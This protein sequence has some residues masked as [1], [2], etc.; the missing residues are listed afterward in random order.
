LQRGCARPV[1]CPNRPSLLFE[2]GGKI[3]HIREFRWAELVLDPPSNREPDPKFFQSCQRLLHGEIEPRPAR[4]P[5]EDRGVTKSNGLPFVIITD[6]C[7][8]LD[9]KVCVV[10]PCF[11]NRYS[12]PD[13]V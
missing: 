12:L 8:G 3:A 1:S 13:I 4:L 10:L 7:R 5:I 6:P 11:V 9:L 2:S